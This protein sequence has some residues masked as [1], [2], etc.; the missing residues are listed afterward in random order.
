[1]PRPLRLLLA[2]PLAVLLAAA[3][4]VAQPLATPVDDWH[5]DDGA[6]GISLD[7][8]YALLADRT[9][10]EVIVAIIDSGVDPTH[11]DLAPVMWRNP[12]E[13]PENGIDD[14]GNGYADDVYGWS[15]LGGPGGNVEHETYEITRLVREGRARFATTAPEADPEGYAEFQELE[16]ELSNKVREFTFYNI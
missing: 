7:A 15:F 1:M 6:P 5:L 14:D 11:P 8:A 2:L 13:T 16:T 4:L 12:G 10:Q 3:P 9:P